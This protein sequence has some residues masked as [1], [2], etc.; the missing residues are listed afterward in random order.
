LGRIREATAVRAFSLFGSALLVLGVSLWITGV[1]RVRT[2][3]AT[4]Q[5]PDLDSI[6]PGAPAVVAMEMQDGRYFAAAEKWNN[7]TPEDGHR[8]F[9]PRPVGQTDWSAPG[10]VSLVAFPWE[11]VK[12]GNNRGMALRLANRTEDEVPFAACDNNL[13]IVQE[14]LNTKGQ[15][16]QIEAF[17]TSWCGNSHHC[18]RLPPGEYW[19]FSAPVYEGTMTTKLRFRLDISCQP[20]GPVYYSNEFEGRINPQQFIPRQR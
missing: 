13:Y 9:Y 19:A 2:P 3:G 15:W 11:S 12:Y 16:Q 7:L 10:Q 20:T 5:K 6:S 18:L 17:P 8:P 1:S 14:A 4:P